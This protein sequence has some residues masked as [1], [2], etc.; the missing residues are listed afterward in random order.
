MPAPKLSPSKRE[1]SRFPLHRVP[2]TKSVRRAEA[3]TEGD[4][5]RADELLVTLALV[6]GLTF[7]P[8]RSHAETQLVIEDGST[9]VGR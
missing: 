1:E 5:E 2:S 6:G 4:V 3:I 9:A 8:T 7:G